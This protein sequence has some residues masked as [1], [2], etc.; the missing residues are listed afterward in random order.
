MA[1]FKTLTIPE[2]VSHSVSA[3]ASRPALGDAEG[4]F[5]TYQDLKYRIQD[6]RELLKTQGIIKGDRVAILSENQINWGV[7]YLGIT[8]YG[9]VAVPILPDFHATAIAHILRHSESKLVLVSSRFSSKIADVQ[10]TVQVSLEDFKV[11]PAGSFIEG[12]LH[13]GETKFSH[14]KETAMKWM[15]KIKHDIAEDDLAVIIYTSGTTGHSKGV[16]LSHKNL[17]FDAVKTLEMVEILPTDR[18]LSILPLAHTYECTLGLLAPMIHGACVYYLD[19]P[20]TAAALLPALSKIKPTIM[21]SVPLV[22]EK[23]YK[24]RILPK[25]TGNFLMRRIYPL[26][27]FRK[28]LNK[29]AGKKLAETF[30]GQLKMFCIGG[31]GLASDVEFFLREAGFPYCIGYGLTETAPLVTGTNPAGTKYKSAGKVLNGMQIKIHDPHP[32]TGEGEV[33]IKG[34][35]VMRGYYRDPEKTSEVLTSDGWFKS[36]DLGVIDKEGYLFIKGR[37]KNMILGPS[38][39]NIYPEEIESILNENEWI[40]E[41]LVYEEGGQL[42]A[43]VF[44]NYEVIDID[45]SHRHSHSEQDS[46]RIVEQYLEKVKNETNARVSK[47]ARIARLVEQTEPFEKTPTQKIK[48]YLYN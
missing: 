37:L 14:L 28:L 18:F 25:L 29:A 10:G 48:R 3:F 33:W 15:G 20:P 43:R 22:I 7:A 13:Q 2:A 46:R 21:L 35:N 16:M 30:G 44:L 38:G 45:I 1:V 27:V 4:K 40:L 42:T 12:I 47:F 36:G 41:S 24:L 11:R 31:A 32:V 23:M 6:I 34:N 9:A 39:E 17:I 8:T 26:P 19:K 5:L